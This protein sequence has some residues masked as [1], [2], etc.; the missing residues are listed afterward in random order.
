VA[1]TLRTKGD[2]G[3][4]WTRYMLFLH[5]RGASRVGAATLTR[6]NPLHDEARRAQPDAMT[7]FYDRHIMPRLIRCACGAKAIQKRRESI[8]PLASGRVLELGC[9]GGLNF[10]HYDP[11]RVESVAGIDP[12]AELRAMAERATE[13]TPVS[14]SV[15]E[16]V[17]EAAPFDD[18]SFDTVLLTFTLCSVQHPEAVLAEARRVLRPCSA[19][20]ASRRTKACKSGSIAWSRCGRRWPAAV[21]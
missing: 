5:E 21:T 12:S 14:I 8:V 4:P 2:P 10:G 18:A 3:P 15:Q 20:T 9:G 1:R 19:N 7:S 6:F 11:A 17:A 13:K 16:G